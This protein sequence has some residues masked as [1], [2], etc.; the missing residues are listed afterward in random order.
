MIILM[1]PLG[2]FGQNGRQ[3]KALYKLDGGNYLPRGWHFAPGVTYML[4][5]SSKRDETVLNPAAENDTLYSGQFNPGGKFGLYAELGRIHLFDDLYVLDS[6]E[7]GI[8]YRMFRGQETFDGKINQADSLRPLQ[9]SQTFNQSYLEA[10]FNLSD[11][12]QIN[13]RFFIQNSLGLGLSYRILSNQN[14]E[15]EIPGSDP[16]YPEDLI[17]SAHYKIAFGYKAT[18]RLFFIPAIETPVLGLLPFEG[19]KSSL[20]YFNSRFHPIIFSLRVMILDK[21]K[22]PDCT[23]KSSGNNPQKLWDPKMDKKKG[24]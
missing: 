13:D 5:T 15:T 1:L 7:Y 23:G 21:R 4:P 14:I 6:Y 11:I 3:N 17:V 20:P 18:E 19:G 12:W 22:G 9:T 8:G 24:R 10:F 2:V 16:Q